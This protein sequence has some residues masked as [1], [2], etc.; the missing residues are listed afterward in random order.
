MMDGIAMSMEDCQGC[1]TDGEGAADSKL[2]QLECTAPG[3]VTLTASASFEFV[4]PILRQD[5]PRSVTAPN[6][7]RAP[8]DP[9]PPRHLI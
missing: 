9:F 8:P 4:M 2:C 3:V 7:L 6:S 5:C 1:P